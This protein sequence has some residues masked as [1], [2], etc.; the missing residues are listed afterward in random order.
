MWVLE[1][2]VFLLLFLLLPVLVYTRHVWWR[3]GSRIKMPFVLYPAVGMKNRR[4]WRSGLSRMGVLCFWLGWSAIVVALSGPMETERE[5]IYLNRGTDIMLVIDQS[6]SMAARDFPPGNRFDAARSVIRNFVGE[7][8][9]DHI[10]L[11]GFSAEAELRV[12][13]TLSHE[14]VLESVNQMQLLELGDGTAIGMG[15]ALAALHLQHSQAEQKVIILLT[16]GVN[17]AGEISPEAAA[18]VAGTS[19]IRIYAIGVG[20]RRE[21]P[22]EVRD[23]SSGQLYRGTITD[24][25]DENSL[26]NLAELSGGSFFSAGSPGTLNSVFEAIGTVESVDRRARVQVHQFP[27]YRD[28]VIW[29]LALI[30]L[31]YALRRIVVGV[32]P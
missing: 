4:T 28:A 30:A 18:Q 9:N 22:V 25:Y 27:L 14:T 26:Q 5:R 19:G 10:G 12:P 3:R 23:P 7:R 15:L 20:S 1:R 29:G 6:A 13:P 32:A 17:N 31:S 2:P 24:S 16:D 8:A 21:V 11:V